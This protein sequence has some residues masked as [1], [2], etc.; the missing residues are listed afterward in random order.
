MLTGTISN[1]NADRVYQG[2]A[3]RVTGIVLLVFFGAFTLDLGAQHSDS[4][5]TVIY[6][7][8]LFCVM[9]FAF[10]RLAFASITT[11]DEGIRVRNVF[12]SFSLKWREIQRFDVDR[13]KVLPG[14][15]LIY[16]R[17]GRTLHAIGIGE[18]GNFSNGSAREIAD[19]LNK[20]LAQNWSE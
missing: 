1:G 12:S 16:T 10:G 17:D 13:W 11:S 9:T 2:R 15:C 3:Q 18:S 8:V 20:V 14:V 19:E 6:S 7:V 5:A 4:A